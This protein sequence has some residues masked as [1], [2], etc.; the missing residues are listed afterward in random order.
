MTGGGYVE[1]GPA[2]RV[3]RIL[4]FYI[5]LM[6]SREFCIDGHRLPNVITITFLH[7]QHLIAIMEP[8]RFA[9]TNGLRLSVL[10]LG[11]VLGFSA[12]PGAQGADA[13]VEFVPGL[14]YSHV[15]LASGPW[16]V[17]V[18]R[19]DRTHSELTFQSS[20]ALN[21]A[22]GLTTLSNQLRALKP[23]LGT[24]LAGVNGDFYQRDR[25]YAGDP[26]GLQICDGEMISA[27]GSATF[28]I[29][30]QGQP[31][32]A[33]VESR[34]TVTWPNGRTT[35]FGLNED[36]DPNPAQATPPP[37]VLYTPALGASTLT[38]TSGLEL[39][40]ERTATTTTTT[41]AATPWLPLKIGETYTARV[42]AVREVG[43]TPI[44]PD[45]L[46]LS[47]RSEVAQTLPKVEA[48]AVLKISTASAPELRGAA[49]ALSGGP[50][51]LQNGRKQDW[52]SGAKAVG[53]TGQYSIRSMSEQHPRTGLGWNDRYFYLVG[54][55]GRNPASVGMTLDELAA[56]FS[57]LGC[58]EAMNLDGGGS[59]TMWAAGRLVSMPSDPGHRERDIA[60]ALLVVRKKSADS[61]NTR[62][63]AK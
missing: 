37:A 52:L 26:R 17:H 20:H 5:C 1:D 39:V 60:N 62:A 50:V 41:T 31:H 46:V 32:V 55:D 33:K 16:S 3:S 18:V 6:Q 44:A 14:A 7:M 56:Y 15:T 11:A 29:D 53:P 24:A 49:T 57:K 43:N 36:R 42:R 40:L 19:V 4:N 22:L 48:G 8:R 47:V 59:A 58:K 61:S 13:F 38:R 2:R 63:A 30:A 28:W 25:D 23:T 45:T 21:G 51:L 9:Q 34:F 35:P 12:G 27:P 54:V 10:L